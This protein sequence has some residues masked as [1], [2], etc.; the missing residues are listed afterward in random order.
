[1]LCE[2]PWAS[3]ARAAQEM[4]RVAAETGRVLM[5]AFHYRYH[6]LM[7]RVQAIVASGEIGTVRE[8]QADFFIP[9]FL[10]PKDIRFNYA[11][12]G[13]GAMDTGCYCINF[14]RTIA[15]AEPTVTRATA[16]E[17]PKQIDRVM[18]AEFFFE[19][20]VT[21]KMGCSLAAFPPV[22]IFA[23]V[24]GEAG[25]LEILNPFVPQYFHALIVKTAKGKRKEH[26]TKEP[27]YNFQLRAFVAA[28]RGE[29]TNR[30]DAP[31]GVKNM[32]VIDAVYEKSGLKVRGT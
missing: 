9:L 15:G 4:A 21:A 11:L 3:N 12:A 16:R 28:A 6:P 25:A 8:I 23:R 32:R 22:K 18:H 20:G 14:I 2:K 13:G 5:E 24:R 7:Q 30:T 1:V 17:M 27:T 19:N 26:F 31:D 29:N 10:R